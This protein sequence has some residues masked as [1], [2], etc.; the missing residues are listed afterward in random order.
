M[1][2][3]GEFI[4]KIKKGVVQ[5]LTLLPAALQLLLSMFNAFMVKFK[6]SF[7]TKPRA[8]LRQGS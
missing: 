6:A 3:L 4:F 8:S 2:L 1:S 5:N 7:N